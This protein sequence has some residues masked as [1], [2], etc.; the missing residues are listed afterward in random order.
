[1]AGETQRIFSFNIAVIGNGFTGKTAFIKRHRTG[2]F[3]REYWPTVGVDVHP[4]VFYTT[5]G[6]ICFNVWERGGTEVLRELCDRPMC[7]KP[8]FLSQ[9]GVILFALAS[10]FASDRLAQQ[11][12]ALGRR[13]PVVLCCNK[14]DLKCRAFLA[15]SK[16]R[17]LLRQ[18]LQYYDVS[19]KTT[20][21]YEKPFLWLSRRLL[22]DPE[23][24]FV[25]MPAPMPPI[26]EFD[27]K[28]WL[29]V[30]IDLRLAL[31]MDLPEEQDDE[32][33]V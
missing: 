2:E 25:D 16:R 28:T 33:V 24:H 1:M 23:L 4:L 13:I 8:F 15:D 26:V 32:N 7:E 19:I 22:G 17:L 14:L 9:A 5:R 21:N 3:L 18:G 11:L 31:E 10:C 29:K 27:R 12:G 30:Q 6:T 20:H